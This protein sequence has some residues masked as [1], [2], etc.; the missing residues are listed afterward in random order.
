ME[1]AY[2]HCS[3]GLWMLT[4][5]VLRSFVRPEKCPTLSPLL[6]EER[7]SYGNAAVSCGS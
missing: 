5:M 4:E 7:P 2:D 1:Q 6:V 3:D